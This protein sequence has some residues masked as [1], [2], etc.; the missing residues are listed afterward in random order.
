MLADVFGKC[1][2]PNMIDFSFFLY[3]M[4]HTQK[5]RFHPKQVEISIICLRQG[6]RDLIFCCLV[7]ICSIPC[8][9]RLKCIYEDDNI[10]SS[11]I[12]SNNNS[13]KS[14][15]VHNLLGISFLHVS[16]SRDSVSRCVDRVYLI[17]YCR[18][19]KFTIN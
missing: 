10:T 8:H 16:Q 13:T 12:Q 6:G 11:L 18:Q 7:G 1:T 9:R 3:F 15:L 14:I 5:L 19:A 2:I 4:V 17:C